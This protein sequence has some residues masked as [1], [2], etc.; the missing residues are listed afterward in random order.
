MVTFPRRKADS[1]LLGQ[2]VVFEFLDASFV[3]LVYSLAAHV[4]CFCYFFECVVVFDDVFDY[5]CITGV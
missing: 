1:M 5:L 4:V 2:V 3:Y